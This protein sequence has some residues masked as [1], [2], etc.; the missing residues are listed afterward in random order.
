MGDS[1]FKGHEQYKDYFMTLYLRETWG[2]IVALLSQDEEGSPKSD[3]VKKR[4]K[5]FNQAL[6]EMYEKQSKWAVPSEKLRLKM[7][8]VAVQAFVPVYKSYLQNIS[9]LEQEGSPGN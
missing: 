9:L 4:L 8:R 1:W 5:E 6:D 7:C 3:S 2:K